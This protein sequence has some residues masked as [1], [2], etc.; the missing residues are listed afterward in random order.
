MT[1][2]HYNVRSLKGPRASGCGVK[3]ADNY[4]ILCKSYAPI[5]LYLA[6]DRVHI[7]HSVK[8]DAW[9]GKSQSVGRTQVEEALNILA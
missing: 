5:S 1:R 7:Q 2:K 4:G 6:A 3:T 8:V 9:N